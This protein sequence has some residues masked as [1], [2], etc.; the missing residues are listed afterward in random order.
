MSMTRRQRYQFR[1]VLLLMVA[2]YGIALHV[3]RAYLPVTNK[4][5]FRESSG[6]WG[7]FHPV[8]AGMAARLRA[9]AQQTWDNGA[10]L[11]LS[12]SMR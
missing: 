2:S 12:N 9:P 6:A 8:D 1:C 5:R 10:W 7:P 3:G 11:S 4:V